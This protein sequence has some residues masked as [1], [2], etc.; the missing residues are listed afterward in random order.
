MSRTPPSRALTAPALA[1][2][3]A[4]A[5]EYGGLTWR[6]ALP[7]GPPGLLAGLLA[8]YALL[9][10]GALIADLLL[11]LARIGPLGGLGRRVAASRLGW[12]L[13]ALLVLAGIA[14]WTA[15]LMLYVRLYPGYHAAL[16][17][18]AL[19]CFTGAMRVAL[20]RQEAPVD[21]PREEPAAA[22]DARGWA[23]RAAALLLCLPVAHLALQAREDGKA[24]ILAHGVIAADMAW[25]GD[26]ASDVDRDGVGWLFTAA[27]PAPFD[28]GEATPGCLDAAPPTSAIEWA[29][30]APAQPLNLLLITVD[31]LRRDHTASDPTGA[32]ARHMPALAK[33]AEQSV[34]FTAA[35]APAAMT[36]PSIAALHSGRHPWALA[37]AP[38]VVA[39]DERVRH[40]LDPGTT[41]APWPRAWPGDPRVGTPA[42]DR[43]PTLAEG[44]GAAGWAT[45]GWPPHESFLGPFGLG[46]GFATYPPD[47]VRDLNINGVSVTGH[48]SAGL[49]TR[50][51]TEH[52]QRGDGRPFF[53]WVHLFDP[54]HPYRWPPGT[55]T[56][57]D[58]DL[59]RYRAEVLYTDLQVARLLT[60]LRQA[61]L[62]RDTV[63][64]FTADHGEAFGE[65]GAGYHSTGL[66]DELVAVPVIVRAPGLAPR[67]VDAP[68]SLVDLAPTIGGL[69]GVAPAPTWQG[70]D[71]G[72]AMRGAAAPGPV[73][74]EVAYEDVH[75]QY[76]LRDGDWTLI[77]DW[78]RGHRQL[79]DVA[80]DPAQLE[81]R[82]VDEAARADAMTA[83]LCAALESTAGLARPPATP[84]PPRPLLGER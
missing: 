45:A 63:V 25:L 48:A 44:L 60:L 20:V 75:R 57:A 24:A 46:R 30:V 81:N 58:T 16:G 66:F 27:D 28:G 21:S 1:A 71:L 6:E 39:A 53:A 41:P 34:V 19:G 72:P 2:G 84:G 70:R 69:L 49:A 15:D 3:L 68:V 32:G 67:R 37:W 65:R 50:F 59:A 12:P 31:A 62:D 40:P 74:S 35:Y 64:V 29:P 8:A 51:I 36:L 4:L 42:L 38:T 61:G 26:R 11:D 73:L 17:S 47:I 80:S 22:P 56:A 82:V 23:F 7:T 79:F 10:A 18:A 78:G 13:F 9:F 76:L 33:L 14:A 52:V 43:H 5:L 77:W 55:E 83:A 54:H